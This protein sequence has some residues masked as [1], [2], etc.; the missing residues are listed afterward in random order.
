RAV[1]VEEK[2]IKTFG[3]PLISRT[4]V[5]ANRPQGFSA[6]QLAEAAHHI[7]ATDRKEGER[8]IRAVP[9]IDTPGLLAPRKSAT[10]LVVYLYIPTVLSEVEQ[11]EA[12]ENFAT[13]LGRA[14]GAE[15]VK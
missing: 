4:M 1:E 13:G 7:A 14:S 5:V 2:A 10:T 8:A 12:A 6:A 3:E 9:L 15:A 11:Q